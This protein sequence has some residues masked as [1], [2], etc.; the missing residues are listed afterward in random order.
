[1]LQKDIYDPVLTA[2][3]SNGFSVK[4][5]IP[6]YLPSDSESRGYATYLEWANLDIYSRGQAAISQ[7][8]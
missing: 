2:Q 7:C 1:M 3:L 4:G 5:L 8:G 6:N